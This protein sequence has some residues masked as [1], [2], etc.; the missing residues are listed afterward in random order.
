M[1]RGAAGARSERRRA[2]AAV[3]VGA[4]TVSLPLLPGSPCWATPNVLQ[5]LP[6][7]NMAGTCGNHANADPL[8]TSYDCHLACF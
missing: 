6:N 7:N 8:A 3:R 4:P 1:T 5:N 2:A